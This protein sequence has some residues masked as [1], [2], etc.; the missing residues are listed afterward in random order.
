MIVG[1]PDQAAAEPMA[2]GRYAVLTMDELALLIPQHQVHALEPAFDVQRSEG[3]DA[4]SIAVAGASW[5]VYC[6]S[7]DLRPI[8]EVPADR[9]ICVLLESGAGLLGVLCDQVVMIEQMGLD[10]LP[11]PRCMRTPGTPLQGLV[12]HAERVLCVT[13]ADDLLGC[14][15]LQQGTADEPGPP[16]RLQGR[17]S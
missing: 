17:A 11:L 9:H 7:K 1:P 10:I 5:P 8:R 16:Q 2:I 6:L 3:E 15:G 13:S 12:L 4:G 14:I